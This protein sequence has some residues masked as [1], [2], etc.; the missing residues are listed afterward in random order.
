MKKENKYIANLITQMSLEQKI[1]A[2]LTLGFTGT[3]A[4]PHI[5]EFITKYHCGGLRLTPHTRQFG[6]YVNPGN[7]KSA[8][9]IPND[10]GYKKGV[11]PAYTTASQYKNTLAELQKTAR[12]RPL[13]LPLH[14]SFDQEG[15]DSANFCFGGVNYFPKPMGV[16]AT[17][18]SIYAYKA[19]KAVA[20]QCRAVGFHWVHSPVLDVN[21]HPENSEIG[22]RSY[23]DDASVVAEYAA[24]ACAGLRDGGLIATGKHFPG[25]GASNVDAH[26]EVPVIT[27]CKEALLKND[28]QPY[29]ELIEKDVLPSIMVAHTI[30]TALDPENIATVSSKVLKGVLRNELGFQGV[31]TTDSMTMGG[32]ASLYGVAEACAMSLQAGADLVLMKA[33]T[34]LVDQT[35]EMIRQFVLDGK[36]QMDDLDDKVYRVLKLKHSYG[37]FEHCTDTS[38]PE[39]VLNRKDIVNLS[40]EIARR[41]ILVA[42]D[43]HNVL[44]LSNSEKILVIEQYDETKFADLGNY[45]G[46][47]YY[48]C[49]QY[50][51]NIAYIETKHNYDA[52]DIERINEKI[53][54]Y[55]TIIVT[56]Y[57]RRDKLANTDAVAKICEAKGKKKK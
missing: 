52:Q 34:D 54:H 22:I 23:S 43:R 16:T 35:F 5:Y 48:S 47:L 7:K 49:I 2:L 45:P 30:F 26:F 36:I 44:P 33:E 57:F 17:G 27:T 29:K 8:V 21:T 51:K 40:I 9:N 28:L 12:S 32:V 42:R 37:L 25:R 10:K 55:D 15:S 24:M 56:N 14:F 31:I 20:E 19:G 6:N 38:A 53:E 39:E 41:A 3:I 50:N 4:A 46:M 13:G 11:E 18:D 1:G